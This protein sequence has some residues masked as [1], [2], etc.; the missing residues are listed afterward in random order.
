MVKKMQ[1]PNQAVKCSG[2][3]SYRSDWSYL[4]GRLAQKALIPE[5]S[6][7]EL[8]HKDQSGLAS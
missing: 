2:Y 1:R 5:K 3:P 4:I 7:L 8:S 6:A